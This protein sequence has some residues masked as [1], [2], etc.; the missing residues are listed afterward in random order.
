ML[1]ETEPR[2]NLLDDIVRDLLLEFSQLQPGE[3]LVGLLHRK[4]ANVHDGESGNA[5]LAAGAGAVA[6]VGVER[7][8]ARAV[9][10]RYPSV[11]ARISGLS[12]CPLQA[13]QNCGLMKAL[14][15][16]RVNSL[17]LSW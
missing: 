17:S 5:G 12:R 14:S 10:A 9:T 13:S 4:R 2:P 11:T 3:E 6:R 7:R 15:R 1:Q 16:L 8:P